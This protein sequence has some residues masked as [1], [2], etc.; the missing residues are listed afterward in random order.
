MISASGEEP[1]KPPC[2]WPCGLG[3][4]LE[5]DV[6]AEGF[7]AGDQVTGQAF[8]VAALYRVLNGTERAA[9]ADAGL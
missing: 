9:V 2:W 4:G 7:Q 1:L 8:G 6:V 3:S 5:G